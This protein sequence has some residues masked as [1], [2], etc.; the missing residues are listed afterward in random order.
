MLRSAL[1]FAVAMVL[2]AQSATAADYKCAKKETNVALNDHD[3]AIA[4]REASVKEMKAEIAEGG[5][6]TD[7]QKKV[8]K[9][10]EDKL[11]KMKDARETS[12]RTAAPRQRPSLVIGLTGRTRRRVEA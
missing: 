8:L 5:G 2:A 7:D 11:A 4:E 1:V 6:S 10:F 12:S 3:I 9:S